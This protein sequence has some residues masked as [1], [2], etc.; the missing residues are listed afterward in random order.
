M[1]YYHYPETPEDTEV[2]RLIATDFLGDGRFDSHPW[3]VQPWKDWTANAKGTR[4]RQDWMDRFRR[5]AGLQ[6][7]E[8][9]L[10]V[11]QADDGFGRLVPD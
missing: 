10:R 3:N 7:G 6:E 8:T 2:M 5:L 4:K 11:V 1:T 9:G